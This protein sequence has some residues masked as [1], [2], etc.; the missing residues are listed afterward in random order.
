VAATHNKDIEEH[1]E[2]GEC[3]EE[4]KKKSES[5][6]MNWSCHI[7]SDFWW[8]GMSWSVEYQYCG[9]TSLFILC[10]FLTFVVINFKDFFISTTCVLLCATLLLLSW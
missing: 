9:S 3:Q 5:C 8:F 10:R 2:T 6:W 1:Q 4:K 7:C